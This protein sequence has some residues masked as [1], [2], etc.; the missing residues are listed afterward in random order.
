LEGTNI[1]SVDGLV[2]PIKDM[3]F[4]G[5]FLNGIE[6]HSDSFSS[7]GSFVGVFQPVD[8]EK[9]TKAGSKL[10][11][12]DFV[13]RWAVSTPGGFFTIGSRYGIY[14]DIIRKKTVLEHGSRL[15]SLHIDNHLLV[16]LF[17]M[18]L[19]ES[20]IHF[21]SIHEWTRGHSN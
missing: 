5:L 2:T 15:T 14:I 20:V 13:I 17:S 1:F 6:L 18:H 7:H 10:F 12:I 3:R 19:F 8:R 11:A 4:V 9:I 16:H 21:F